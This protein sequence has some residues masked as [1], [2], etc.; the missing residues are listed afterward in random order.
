MVLVV[1]WG[2][3]WAV[4]LPLSMAL[5]VSAFLGY[6]LARGAER[7]F[8]ETD[9]GD[10]SASPTLREP[11]AT[12][13]PSATI[14][15]VIFVATATFAVFSYA[16]PSLLLR[17]VLPFNLGSGQLP[18]ILL[19]VV[20]IVNLGAALALAIYLVQDVALYRD[21]L[22]RGTAVAALAGTVAGGSAGPFAA[23]ARTATPV[24]LAAL[25]LAL[26]TEHR[27]RLGGVLFGTRTVGLSTFPLFFVS[28]LALARIVEVVRIAG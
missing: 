4:A 12:R 9:A 20:F 10:G 8:T 28:G 26:A 25:V 3:L 21:W 14:A 15:L 6:L 18:S 19:G 1:D 22:A 23:A 16:F 17:Y 24:A 5:T 7:E 2:N 27:A 13:P 11:E